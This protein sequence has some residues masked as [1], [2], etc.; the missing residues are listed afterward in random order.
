MRRYFTQIVWTTLFL[1]PFMVW[2]SVATHPAVDQLLPVTPKDV[3]VLRDKQQAIEKAE[4]AAPI[5]PTVL[6]NTVR[7]I[8]LTDSAPPPALHLVQ[9]YATNVA[10]VGQNMKPWP[11]VNVVPGG[12]A[13]QVDQASK[14]DPYNSAMTVNKAWVSTNVTFYLKGRVRPIT[15]YLYTAA[16]TAKGLDASVTIK[17]DG[18]PPGTRPLAVQN[19][20]GT[21]DAL[22]NALDHAPGDNWQTVTLDNANIPVGIH[23]W[24]SPDRHHA[25]VRLTAG[26][27]V[28]PE[29]GSQASS[30]DHTITAYEFDHV[31]LMLW[32][33][34]AEGKSFQVHAHN[35]TALIAGGQSVI[36][37]KPSAVNSMIMR[38][39]GDK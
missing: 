24:V 25:I 30:P 27:L 35:A 15:L 29:W 3:K 7:N 20:T 32:V 23:Y 21:S 8:N 17:V 13:I 39:K 18:T 16:N 4:Q 31:P 1:T 12:A 10:F 11:I 34:S 26:T 5:D 22:L 2:A 38:L 36:A 28:M 19:I 14:D 9:G 33:D 37:R 6:A